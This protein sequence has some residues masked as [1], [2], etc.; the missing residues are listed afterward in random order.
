[1]MPAMTRNN[2]DKASKE[3]VKIIKAVGRSVAETTG[4]TKRVERP[5][6]ERAQPLSANVM[7][8]LLSGVRSETIEVSR[9]RNQFSMNTTMPYGSI[10]RGGGVTNTTG[11]NKP[12]TCIKR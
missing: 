1:M 2:D 6:M 4:V 9:G 11:L 7:G 5:A 3:P 10:M 12:T 8:L